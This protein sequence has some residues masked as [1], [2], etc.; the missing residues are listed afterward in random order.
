MIKDYKP[1]FVEE[2]TEYRLAFNTEPG[3]GLSFPCDKDGNVD[4]SQ[5][6]APAVK[7][8]NYA[9]QHPEKYPAGW[10]VVEKTERR[11]RNPATGICNCGERIELTDSYLGACD[12][13]RCGQW[14]NLSGQELKDVSR[15]NDYGELDYDY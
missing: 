3:C 10:K 4:L 11:Y 1:S 15:W 12:C 7:N 5:M 8:Y 6:E 2:I 14:W 13:P 9:L